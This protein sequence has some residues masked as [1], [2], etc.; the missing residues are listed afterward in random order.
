[1]WKFF[2]WS[3]TISVHVLGDRNREDYSMKFKQVK[4]GFMK[5]FEGC[6]RGEPILGQHLFHPEAARIR[7]V[8]TAEIF[9]GELRVSGEVFDGCEVFLLPKFLCCT[10]QLSWCKISIYVM[11]KYS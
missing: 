2:W 7:G 11:V 1:M 8:S 9:E 4:T 10:M 3:G 6:W 5:R